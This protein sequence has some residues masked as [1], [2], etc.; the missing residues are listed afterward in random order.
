MDGDVLSLS[1]PANPGTGRGRR[2]ELLTNVVILATW[3]GGQAVSR[4]RGSSTSRAI[5]GWDDAYLRARQLLGALSADLREP[6]DLAFHS[7]MNTREVA[8]KLGITLETARDRIR[9]ARLELALQ[10][11]ADP[12]LIHFLRE[13]GRMTATAG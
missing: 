2:S 6:A 10:I 1:R 7:G 12:E 9:A 13:S 3:P 5:K 4:P 8:K 11:Q